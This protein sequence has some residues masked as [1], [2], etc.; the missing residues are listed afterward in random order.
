MNKYPTAHLKTTLDSEWDIL[1]ALNQTIYTFPT[2]PILEWVASHQDDDPNI[3]IENLTLGAQLNIAADELAT[4]AL[5]SFHQKP[6][7]PMDPTSEVLFHYKNRTITRDFKHT[8]RT[9]IS[10]PAQQK[11]YEERFN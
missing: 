1:S 6:R 9:N 3:R 11:Y 7:V 4:Y 8:M 2:V 5:Q 10:L